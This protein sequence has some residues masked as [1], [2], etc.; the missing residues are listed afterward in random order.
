MKK[1]EKL[2]PSAPGRPH[3]RDGRGDG[4]VGEPSAGGVGTLLIQ[5]VRSGTRG[6][7]SGIDRE[8]VAIGQAGGGKSDG[9]EFLGGLEGEKRLAIAG[10][11][12][13]YRACCLSRSQGDEDGVLRGGGTWRLGHA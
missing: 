9:L 6:R 3:F 8:T 12:V 1:N 11:Q 2:A 4:K 10:L 13:D 7:S 5:T